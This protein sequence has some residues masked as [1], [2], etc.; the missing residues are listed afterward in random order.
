M[1]DIN[2]GHIE[3]G[4]EPDMYVSMAESD[5]SKGKDTIIE[6][7]RDLIHSASR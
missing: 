6:K 7:A 3:F 5:K 2:K 1:Y 4:I